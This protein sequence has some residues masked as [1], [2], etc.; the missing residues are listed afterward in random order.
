MTPNIADIIC[1]HVSLSVRC[2]DRLYLHAYMPKQQTSGGLCYFLHDHR[3]Y[4]IPSAL[5]RPMHDRFVND[6][7][8]FGARRDIPPSMEHGLSR[9]TQRCRAQTCR[10]SVPVKNACRARRG[11]RGVAN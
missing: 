2:I 11:H 5:F 7:E 6:V 8:Q 4:P 3:W 9:T 1:H 10:G